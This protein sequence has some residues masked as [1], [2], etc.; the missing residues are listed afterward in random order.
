MNPRSAPDRTIINPSARQGKLLPDLPPERGTICRP[1]QEGSLQ[2]LVSAKSRPPPGGRS[3]LR[4]AQGLSLFQTGDLKNTSPQRK[5]GIFSGVPSLALRACI[6]Q[7]ENEK[8]A[9][10]SRSAP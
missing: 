5:R 8:D 2:S 1:V 6:S 7:F 10:A 9:R 3:P 4:L